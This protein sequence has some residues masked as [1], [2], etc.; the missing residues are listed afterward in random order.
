MSVSMNSAAADLEL[1]SNQPSIEVVINNP[2][3]DPGDIV[4]IKLHFTWW[5]VGEITPTKSL[6]DT[7]QKR[8]GSRCLKQSVVLQYGVIGEPLEDRFDRFQRSI[9]RS[10]LDDPVA[11]RDS[12]GSNMSAENSTC[13]VWFFPF[14]FG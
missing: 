13:Y 14:V 8:S 3:T 5:L 10:D 6:A 11:F 7:T 4:L 9:I 12:L 1:L 2:L